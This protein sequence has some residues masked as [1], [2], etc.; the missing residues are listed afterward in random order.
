M[1][2]SLGL[3]FAGTVFFALPNFNMF[4]IMPDFIGAI[5]IMSGLSKLQWIDGNFEDARKGAKYLLW[6]SVLRLVLCIFA[7]GG[8][9]DYLVPFA[10]IVCVLE[11]MFMMKLN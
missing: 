3:I 7:N 4:D 8:R 10:F 6:V 1:R 9:A 2:L 11:I 5:L